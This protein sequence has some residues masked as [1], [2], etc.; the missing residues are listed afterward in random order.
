MNKT[1]ELFDIYNQDGTKTGRIAT[2]KE[3]IAE[4]LIINTANVFIV[5]SLNQVLLHKDGKP[6][7]LSFNKWRCSVAGKNSAGNDTLETARRETLEE[8]GLDIPKDK[9][10]LIKTRFYDDVDRYKFLVDVYV[11]GNIDKSEGG[12]NISFSIND[13]KINKDEIAEVKWFNQDY[14]RNWKE[15]G[16]DAY[17][18]KGRIFETHLNDLLEWLDKK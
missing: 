12:V 3:V 2:M 16:L 7:H 17:N 13:M 6:S 15:N 4:G 9:F 11:V 5:N 8:L 14:L 1:E 10:R 18:G